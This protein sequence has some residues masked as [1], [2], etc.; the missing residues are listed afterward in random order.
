M[1]KEKINE[2]IHGI[3]STSYLLDIDENNNFFKRL[4]IF[5]N[6]PITN[7]EIEIHLN[8]NH[9]AEMLIEENNEVF[10]N[11]ENVDARIEQEK[12]MFKEFNE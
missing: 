5:F 4:C 9:S 7:G 2:Y 10:I 3:K 11:T 6:H 1:A 8:K 12:E